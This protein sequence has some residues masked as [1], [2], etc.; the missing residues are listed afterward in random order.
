MKDVLFLRCKKLRNY[1][2]PTLMYYKYFNTDN[3]VDTKFLDKYI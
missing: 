2:P 1:N 3:E